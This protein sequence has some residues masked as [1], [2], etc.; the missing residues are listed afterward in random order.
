MDLHFKNILGSII[1][2]DSPKAVPAATAQHQVAPPAPVST[3]TSYI[4][5]T[6]LVD[7]ADHSDDA[8]QLLFS[9]TNWEKAPVFIAIQKY[10]AP[11]EGLAVDEKTKFSIALKQAQAQDGI[12]PSALLQNLDAMRT[13]LSDAANAFAQ[14]VA[15]KSATEVDAKKKRAE[16]LQKQVQQLT[17]EAFAAQQKLQ[18]AQHK[19]DIAVQTRLSEI[20]QAQAKYSSL[21]T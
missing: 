12:D 20:N 18:S 5:P 9:K 14:S 1:E 16:D 15:A 13:S 11:M 19:F 4:S 8:Y 21:L 2:D 3:P 17:E 7:V 6:Q 10:L